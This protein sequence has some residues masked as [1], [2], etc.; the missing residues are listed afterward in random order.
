M[1]RVLKGLFDHQPTVGCFTHNSVQAKVDPIF[2]WLW[3]DS[4]TPDAVVILRHHD[5]RPESGKPTATI[6]LESGG[7]EP[8]PETEE[9]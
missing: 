8:S 3:T 7:T 1:V 9:S 6:Y 2:E 4:T 5:R